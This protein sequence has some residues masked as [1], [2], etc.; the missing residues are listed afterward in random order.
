MVAQLER[1]CKSMADSLL[2][3]RQAELAKLCGVRKDLVGVAVEI[4]DNIA[5]V[6]K[7]FA[8][9]DA[10]ELLAAERQLISAPTVVNI[11]L[12]NYVL[13]VV[14]PGQP[15]PECFSM[16]FTSAED[17]IFSDLEFQP[18]E[19]WRL[20][21]HPK[22]KLLTS[23]AEEKQIIESVQQ[24]PEGV[25]PSVVDYGEYQE[26]SWALDPENKGVF[27]HLS[28][29]GQIAGSVCNDC[30][31]DSTAL[32]THVMETGVWC[33]R[34]R[35][36]ALTGTKR[37]CFGVTQRP[38]SHKSPN[39]YQ[40]IWGWATNG[41][42]LPFYERSCAEA[43]MHTGEEVLIRLDCGQGQLT[44]FWPAT[45]WTDVLKLGSRTV[46]KPLHAAVILAWNGNK[47][48]LLPA[49]LWEFPV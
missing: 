13:P 4:A 22:G 47:V 26:L 37:V 46:G 2:E 31:E 30:Y 19:Q 8:E 48:E 44:A 10:V 43:K 6:Q 36:L 17:Q 16:D 33:W 49:Q 38:F 27:I 45:G 5:R 12:P 20:V 35:M 11:L 9:S 3:R 7:A 41:C 14:G 21:A 23:E 15:L 28:S 29:S 24:E 25:H 34:L 18:D 32:S 39:P 1:Q 42:S 40:R